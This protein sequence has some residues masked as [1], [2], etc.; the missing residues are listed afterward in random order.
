MYNIFDDFIFFLALLF[1]LSQV[2]FVCFILFLIV[3]IIQI[4]GAF[5]FKIL[6]LQSIKQSFESKKIK[7]VKYKK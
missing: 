3:A 7:I 5:A 6:L 2:V 4:I 1:K